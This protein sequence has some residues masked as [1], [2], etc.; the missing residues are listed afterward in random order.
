MQK[1][2]SRSVVLAMV[3]RQE[4]RQKGC[5]SPQCSV[6]NKHKFINNSPNE[7]IKQLLMLDNSFK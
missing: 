7:A 6:P 3:Q 4:H 1:V 2:G 5:F